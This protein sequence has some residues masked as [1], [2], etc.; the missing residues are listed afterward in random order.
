[1]RAKV[2]IVPPETQPRPVTFSGEKALNHIL[3]RGK[4]ESLNEPSR[5]T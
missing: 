4:Q 5:A 2:E 3:S 1:M